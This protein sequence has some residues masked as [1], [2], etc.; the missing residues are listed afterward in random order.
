MGFFENLTKPIASAFGNGP[1][2]QLDDLIPGIGDAK[3]AE[4]QNKESIK[5]AEINRQFQERMSSTA[6]QRAMDDM[7]KA[8]LNPALAYQ[9]G[10]ASAPSG[11]Q[12]TIQ[13]ESKTALANMGLAAYTGISSAR[14]QNRG[15]DQQ[16]QMNDSAIKLN[17]TNAAKNLQQAENIRLDNKIKRKYE[18]LQDR[19]TGIIKEASST[20]DN[21]IKGLSNSAKSFGM[22]SSPKPVEGRNIKVLGPS[23]YKIPSPK[24]P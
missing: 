1:L 3:A 15:L 13:S 10:G 4:K 14:A 20:Y 9:Q 6:Y 12:A 11:A 7:K 19:A 24:K 18:P 17:T 21:L 8:G 5:Q 22:F 2:G 16:A 23:K